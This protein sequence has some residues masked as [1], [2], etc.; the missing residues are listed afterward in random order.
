MKTQNDQNRKLISRLIRLHIDDDR[1]RLANLRCGLRDRLHD[2]PPNLERV[3]FGLSGVDLPDNNE[4]ME[5]YTVV[6]SL[7]GSA[8]D[9]VAQKRGVS[10]AHACR[11]LL[12]ASDSKSLEQRFMAM[13]SSSDENLPGHLRHAVSLLKAKEIGIDWDI[14]LNDVLNWEDA[15]KSVQKRWGRDYYHHPNIKETD[16]EQTIETPI[17]CP[18]CGH[19]W[20]KNQTITDP[21]TNTQSEGE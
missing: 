17:E 13:L 20:T 12:E 11:T 10:L 18:Q 16:D 15:N 1:A 9:K 21:T 8:H 6:G 14:L 2:T 19:K 7:F 3:Y 5:W 4:R